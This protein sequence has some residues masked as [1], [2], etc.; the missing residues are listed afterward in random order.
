MVLKVSIAHSLVVV[1]K[2]WRFGEEHAKTNNDSRYHVETH[3]VR[4]EELPLM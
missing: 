3:G 2:P 4:K 1:N